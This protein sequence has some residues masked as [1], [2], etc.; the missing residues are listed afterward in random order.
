M[1]DSVGK[2]Y[3]K[4]LEEAKA[5][6]S[7]AN[8]GFVMNRRLPIFHGISDGKQYSDLKD[9]LSKESWTKEDGMNDGEN[10]W[11]HPLA[12]FQIHTHDKFGRSKLPFAWIVAA[13]MK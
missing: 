11:S 2:E 6:L 1:I 7:P 13:G 4:L 9:R 8:F 3:L 10:V 12:S 5:S